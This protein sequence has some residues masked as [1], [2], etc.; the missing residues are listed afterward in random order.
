VGHWYT[1]TNNLEPAIAENKLRE[2]LLYRLTTYTVRVPPLR[3]RREEIPLLLHYFMRQLAKQYALSP[4]PFSSAVLEA[5]QVH[6]WP[7]NLR[8]METFVKGFLLAGGKELPFGRETRSRAT[9]DQRMSA[10]QREVSTSAA[11]SGNDCSG[12]DSLKSLVQNVKL[13]AEKNAIAAALERTGW[14]RK[15]A[16]RLLKVSYRTLLYKIEQYQMRSPDSSPIQGGPA[17][18]TNGNGFGG[19]GHAQ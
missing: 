10:G 5:C 11:L 17:F 16:A 8:E 2:D 1:S 9:S 19:N 18:R 14:N 3:E 12:S 6:Y 13:E 15:A 4:R 7:G